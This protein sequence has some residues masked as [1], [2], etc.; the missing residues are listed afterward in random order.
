MVF[1]CLS[2][3]ANYPTFLV[4]NLIWDVKTVLLLK[5]TIAEKMESNLSEKKKRENERLINR[6]IL[7]VILNAVTFFLLKVPVLLNSIFEFVINEIYTNWYN[8]PTE[9]NGTIEY[10]GNIFIWLCFELFGCDL[11]EQFSNLLYF[12]SLSLHL[13][14]YYKFDRN[15]QFSFHR[16][17]LNK[18]FKPQQKSIVLRKSTPKFRKQNQRIYKIEI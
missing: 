10:D 8:R 5:K 2:D 13:Y 11:F 17:I 6:A 14:F 12:L 15:F 3:V 16:K 4:I 18:K 1:N 7:M 9:E